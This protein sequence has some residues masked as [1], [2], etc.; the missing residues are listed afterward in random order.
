[1]PS[2]E[3]PTVA[4]KTSAVA[5]MIFI[6]VMVAFPLQEE[7]RPNGPGFSG[8]VDVKLALRGDARAVRRIFERGGMSESRGRDHGHGESDDRDELLHGTSP[9]CMNSCGAQCSASQ[10][11]DKLKPGID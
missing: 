4:A 6:N 2:A 9:I 11:A 5:A 7:S 3:T 10:G 1:M 8:S